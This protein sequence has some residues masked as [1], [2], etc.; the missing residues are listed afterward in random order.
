[1]NIPFNDLRRDVAALREEI[2][3]AI[4][5][6]LDRGYFILGPEGRAFEEVFAK[7]VGVA[8]AFGVGN[9]TDGIQIALMALGSGAGD[10]VICPALTAAPTAL[11]IRAIGAVPV[12]ADIDPATYTLD[13]AR[14]HECITEKTRTIVPVHLYGLPANMPE[15]LRIA[16]AHE[17]A[18]LEDCA[19]AH[20]ATIDGKVAGSM[21]PIAAFSFYPTKNLGA[22]GDGGLVATRDSELAAKVAKIRDLGQSARYVHEVQ[23]LNSRLDELQAAILQV[24]LV[25]LE[26][27]NEARRQRAGWY[28]EMLEDVPELT[29]PVEPVGYRHIYHLFVV[30]HPRRDALQAY[31][32]DRG[33]GTD[34]HYPM[35][36]NQQHVFS[37]SRTATGGTPIADEAV[38]T[39]L[40]LPMFPGLTQEEVHTV[41]QAIREFAG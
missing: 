11:A 25:H 31:L 17:I 3:A 14:L 35:P 9:G 21:A 13:P 39:I 1:M 37:G 40:S 34:V 23:G 22:Y 18:V 19:Q 6:V 10:E 33:I 30:R 29:L 15:I 32:K 8:D 24:K 16:E 12:F 26:E 7:M 2:D 4:A 5:R 41:G 20:G 27:Q 36:L 38:R 28:R